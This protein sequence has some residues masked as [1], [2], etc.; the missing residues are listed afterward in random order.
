MGGAI[1]SQGYSC[2][3][4]RNL[5]IC[6]GVAYRLANLVIDSACCKSGKCA[7]KGNFAGKRKA[8]ANANHICLRYACLKKSLRELLCKGIHLKGAGKV[9]AKGHHIAILFTCGK[10][11]CSKAGTGIFIAGICKIYHSI[12]VNCYLFNKDTINFHAFGI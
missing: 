7:N 3:R 1:L 10:E 12:W 11:S 6:V 5:Y 2:V 4:C 9:C 8:G